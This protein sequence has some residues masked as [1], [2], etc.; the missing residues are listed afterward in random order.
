[1]ARFFIDRPIFAIVL[2]LVIVIVGALAIRVLP[3][4][5][6]PQITL[7]TINVSAQYIGA[8]AEV[9]QQSLAQPIEDKVNGVEGMQYMDSLSAGNGSYSLNVTFALER[10][11]DMATVLTQ[12]RVAT[13]TPLLPTEVT[14]SGVTT[15]KQSPDVLMYYAL[16][17]PKGT[18]DPLFLR[19][20]GSIYVTDVLR[21]I[22]GVGA[23]NEYGA[24]YGM[25]IWLDP[26]LMAKYGVI[27]SDIVQTVREQNAQ[28]P[29]GSLGQ[30]PA[31]AEQAFQFNLLVQGRLVSTEEFGNIILRSDGRGGFVRLHDVARLEL[32]Q[33]DYTTIG[34]FNGGPAAV[35]SINLTPDANALDVSA[36]IRAEIARLQ[37]D[38][39]TDLELDIVNDNTD[40]VIES[41]KE[42]LHTLVEAMLLVLVVVML[43]LQSWR[44]TLI[45]MLA[46]PVS[47]I[48]TL[49]VFLALGF[50]INTLTLFA[51]VLAIGIVV[52]DAIVVVEAVE[53][54]MRSGLSARDATIKAMTEVS[55]PVIAIALVLCAVFV[56]VSFLSGI[57]GVM[58]RQFG[59]TVAVSVLLSAFVALTLTPALC[60]ILLKP[61]LHHA[62]P[63]VIQRFFA[64]FNRQFDRLT[65]RYGSAV[66]AAVRH[67]GRVMLLLLVLIVAT[68]GL[69]RVVKSTFVPQEDQ[70]YLLA[71]VLLPEAATL[72]RTR[73]VVADVEKIAAG[74][75]GVAKTLAITG[76]NI[77]YGTAQPNAGLVILKLKPWSERTDDSESLRQ[78]LRTFYQRTNSIA[79]ARVLPFNPPP[80]P[81]LSTTGGVSLMI[82]DKSGGTPLELEQ[83]AGD[84]VL[85]AQQRPELAQVMSKFQAATPAYRLHIDRDKAKK[86]DVP[87]NDVFQTLQAYLGGVQINDFSLFGRTY[88]VTVQAEADAR[89]NPQVLSLLHTRSSSGEMIPLSTLVR[90]EPAGVPVVLKRFNGYP[91]AE[92]SATEAAGYSSGDAMAVLEQLARELP[93]GY[94]YEWA[95]LSRQEKASAGQTG[96]VLLLAVL[97]V[98]LFLAALY[99]S[100][101]VPFAVLLALPLGIFGAQFALWLTGL[102]SSIYT[103]IGLVLVIGLAAK[104]AILI[105]EFAKMKREQGIDVATASI[106]AAK[107]RLRPILMTSLAF[108]LGVVP[109]V[110]AS[111]AGAA[112]R[113]T[114]GLAVFSGMLFATVLAVFLVPVLYYQIQSIAERWVSRSGSDQVAVGDTLADSGT[115]DE[116][117]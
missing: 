101:T 29:A 67:A 46:V 85:A 39:P 63:G 83:V 99:E 49:A 103:Q 61:H 74:I 18:Y 71:A 4:A 38:F 36:R 68:G 92:I 48:G 104:N 59:L 82:Q 94:G 14:Q 96:P 23:V 78:V 43:F 9:V 66:S 54:H 97:F 41:M 19:N 53:L 5:Q 88:K 55:G 17:S 11:A 86:L 20:Y 40:F 113:V 44:A 76:T 89:S 16:H 45:P 65:E 102:P 56:P 13:A 52:D 57:T 110:L 34:T 47:L 42:V 10:D 12:N 107:L 62:E 98:F 22:P 60:A 72:E 116:Q 73:Q 8:N 3:I 26:A 28:V 77:L 106:E 105:V 24:E 69:F 33:K 80:I 51:L 37:G 1:M 7:P 90:A 64:A 35:Y 93:E 32:G 30:Y 114:L 87:L 112:S 108:I 84:F 115:P 91:T 27:A 111:G 31:P 117:A 109:L 100:W 81:G 15:R 50:S 95:G 75:P 25:R 79:D 70:G 2:S 21:R 6:Y 58:F